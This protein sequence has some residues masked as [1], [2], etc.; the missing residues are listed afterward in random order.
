MGKVHNVYPFATVTPLMA[1]SQINNMF[2]GLIG[3]C[4]GTAYLYTA[5]FDGI[6]PATHGLVIEH[7]DMESYQTTLDA[8]LGSE[9][10]D[11]T[12]AMAFYMAQKE[13]VINPLA[14]L[15][16]G[17]LMAVSPENWSMNNYLLAFDM[18]V[19]DPKKYAKAWKKLMEKS[20]GIIL[21][22]Q[23]YRLLI[24]QGEAKSRM[25]WQ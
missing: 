1:Y 24:L 10:K 8:L 4:M 19:V 13:A 2:E 20:K 3:K 15:Q 18:A 22:V 21:P 6:N 5:L 9:K 14:S 11:P 17:V 23:Q 7:S 25:Q 12:A 16:H